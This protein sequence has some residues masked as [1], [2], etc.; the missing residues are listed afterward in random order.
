MSRQGERNSPEGPSARRLSAAAST[1]ERGARIGVPFVRVGA[2][3]GAKT[4]RGS[5][6]VR[7]SL[8]PARTARM[9]LK[10]LPLVALAISV[11]GCVLRMPEPPLPPQTWLSVDGLRDWA[12]S[13]QMSLEVGERAWSI[14]PLGGPGVVTPALTEPAHVRLVGLETCQEYA[15]F[16]ITPGSA[17][18]INFALDGSVTVVDAAQVAHAMGPGLV[19]GP[20]SDCD[21][22]A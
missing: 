10:A 21:P 2:R 16:D 6:F 18:I 4:P 15:S 13:E 9:P 8:A 22:S 20:P 5:R 19:E 3:H 7:I 17:W 14:T 1:G 11:A 12:H